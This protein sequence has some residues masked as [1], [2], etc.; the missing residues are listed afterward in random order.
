MDIIS[1]PRECP[2]LYIPLTESNTIKLR[3]GH[4]FSKEAIEQWKRISPTCPICRKYMSILSYFQL[5]KKIR[6]SIPRL[7]LLSF[8]ILGAFMY[9]I[10]RNIYLITY[11]NKILLIFLEV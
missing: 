6:F 2:I 3:C 7:S 10:A 11:E 1:P 8:S 5:K 4:I 9:L